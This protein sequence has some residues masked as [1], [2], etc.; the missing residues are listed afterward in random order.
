MKNKKQKIY[1]TLQAVFK[2]ECLIVGVGNVLRGDDAFG[3]LLI[4]RIK[5]RIGA[6][7][8]DAGT[9]PENYLGKIVKRAPRTVLIADAAQLGMASG[10]YDILK[11]KDIVRSGFTTHDLSP[12]MFIEYLEKE[13]AADIYMLAVQPEN[14]DFGEE[15]SPNVK[16][17]LDEMTQLIEEAYNA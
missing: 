7:C 9:A 6:V 5:D 2:K 17:T 3:P 13:L 1:R 14:V 10:E 11:K 4:E 16:K 8:I 15:V 12:V